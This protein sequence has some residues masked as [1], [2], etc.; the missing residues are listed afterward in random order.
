MVRLV[1]PGV[2]CWHNAAVFAVIHLM[3][4]CGINVPVENCEAGETYMSHFSRWSRLTTS[5]LASPWDALRLFAQEFTSNTGRYTVNE[6]RTKTQDAFL[7]FTA[8]AGQ[9]QF[10]S[11]GIDFFSFM[12]PVTQFRTTVDRCMECHSQIGKSSEGYH[13]L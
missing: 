11:N 6:I 9:N 5:E 8:L 1:N 3:K 10:E 2:L 7:F 4:V 13:T 12:R